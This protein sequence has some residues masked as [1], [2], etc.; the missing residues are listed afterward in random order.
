MRVMFNTNFPDTVKALRRM[1]LENTQPKRRKG[2]NLVK[3]ESKKYGF[4][5]YARFSHNGKTLPTKFN[6]Y[7]NDPSTAERFAVENKSRLVEGYLARQDGRMFTMLEEFYKVKQSHLSDRCRNEYKRMIIDKFMP[8]LRREKITV[9]DQIKMTTLARYQDYL[10]AQGLKPQTVN[11]NLKP[12]K[13]ILAEMARRGITQEDSGRQIRSIPVKQSDTKMRGCYELGRIKGVFNRRWKEEASYLLCALIYTAGMRNIEIRRLR[14]GDIQ[15]M[16]GCRFICIKESKT[17]SG[18]RLIPLHETIYR[19]LKAWAVKNGKENTI[20][21]DFKNAEP[22]NRANNELARQLKVSD[23][24]L[25]EENISFYSGR[26]YWKTLMS[27]E[28]L[29][30]DVEE[31]FMGHKVSGN[32]AKLYNHRDKQGRSR[33]AK[34]AKQVVSILDSC[35]FKTKP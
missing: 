16:N 15:I 24:E 29:G 3:I 35:I 7:T 23:E 34:K 26:H 13:N 6:T 19:K 22:F 14:M 32:V 18:I 25:E 1:D 20:L 10:L 30:E 11:N 28:G 21:F 8:F 33:M 27:A 31:I 4:L 12:V 5:Y 9:F 17:P 2:F